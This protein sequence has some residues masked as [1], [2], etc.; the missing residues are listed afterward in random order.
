MDNYDD[1]FDDDT[2]VNASLGLVTRNGVT[3]RFLPATS[4]AAPSEPAPPCSHDSEHGDLSAIFDDSHSWICGGEVYKR[5]VAARTADA[6]PPILPRGTGSSS[7]AP[8]VDSETT[9]CVNVLSC[10][11]Q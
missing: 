6:Y 5:Y 9:W 11:K 10:F 3:T 4:A 2:T 7:M 8:S 1:L